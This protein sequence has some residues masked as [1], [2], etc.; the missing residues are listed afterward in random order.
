MLVIYAGTKIEADQLF[1]INYYPVSG[2]VNLSITNA[3]PF[4]RNG[5]DEFKK[6]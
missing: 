4:L 6:N 1:E 5:N 3:K 2:I